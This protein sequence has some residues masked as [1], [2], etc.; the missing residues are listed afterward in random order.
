MQRS[1]LAGRFPDGGRSVHDRLPAD[2]QVRLDPAEEADRETHD[3][4]FEDGDGQVSDEHK[5]Y[6]RP[7]ILGAADPQGEGVEQQGQQHSTK[8][9][10]EA[11]DGVRRGFQAP[12][13]HRSD[14][15]KQQHPNQGPWI[16]DDAQSRCDVGVGPARARGVQQQPG[17][18][19]R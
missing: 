8:A 10:E 4:A 12:F 17:A 15:A 5:Q 9:D 16:D 19:E 18:K 7:P 2:E 14:H 1:N 13:H 6:D 11:E 3:D